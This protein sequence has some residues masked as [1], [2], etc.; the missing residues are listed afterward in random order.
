MKTNLIKYSLL[1]IMF[2]VITATV[3]GQGLPQLTAELPDPGEVL[4]K[5]GRVYDERYVYEGMIYKTFLYDRPANE[6]KFLKDY[7]EKVSSAGY[8]TVRDTVE[9]EKALRI[10]S[11]LLNSEMDALL[12]YDFQGYMLFMVPEKLN[13]NLHNNGSFSTPTPSSGLPIFSVTNT[14]KPTSTTKP[15]IEPIYHESI[16]VG[17]RYFLGNYDQG[18]GNSQIPWIVIKVEG[19]KALLL[20]EKI[21]DEKPYHDKQVDVIKWEN[22]SLRKWLNNDFYNK[23]FSSS[24]KSRILE[25]VNKNPATSGTNSSYGYYFYVEGGQ[26]TKDK[27]FL[28]SIDEANDFYKTIG[29]WR[30][31]YTEKVGRMGGYAADID[32]GPIWWLRSP[33][34]SE[35]CAAMV[36]NQGILTNCFESA[37]IQSIGVRPAIWIT[38]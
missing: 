15:T 3:S 10:S 17:Q 22:C 7:S 23:A 33:G 32:I 14:P 25:V 37:W 1:M 35:N 16:S 18:S 28:L 24:E 36:Y 29:A 30:C 27:V 19:Y 8:K 2:L 21:L 20:S 11:P 26:D 6:E 9:G 31:Y 13:F 12:L 38:F 5:N 4:G 34:M